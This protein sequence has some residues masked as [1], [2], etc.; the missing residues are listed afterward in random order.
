MFTSS[1][2]EK[3]FAFDQLGEVLFLTLS[4]SEFEYRIQGD[5]ICRDHERL[6]MSGHVLGR[7]MCEGTAVFEQKLL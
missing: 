7:P 6:G 4:S 2:R 3:D 5:N 1:L